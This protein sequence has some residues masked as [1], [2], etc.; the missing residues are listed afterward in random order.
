MPPGEF[1]HGER[2][3]L[4]LMASALVCMLLSIVFGAFGALYYIPD[5]ATAMAERGVSLVQLR[6]LH[7]TFASAWIF[8]GAVTCVL[9]FL[10][11]DSGEPSDGDRRR[12]RVQMTCWGVAGLGVVVTLPLG[13]TTGR[14]YLGFHPAISVLIVAGWLLFA[15]TFFRRV[16]RGFWQRPV[17]VYMWAV[18]ILYFLWTFTEGH[19][20]LLQG[21]RERPVADLQIQWKSCGTLVA[22]FNQ[23]VYGSLIYIAER[24]SGD[25]R[26]A[27][28]KAAFSLLGLGLLNSFTNYAHHTYHLPQSHVIKWVA[29]VVSMLE[30]IILVEVFREVTASLARRRGLYEGS[31]TVTER[32]FTL[33]KRWNLCLLSLAILI[34]VP[35]LNA[36][37]HGTHVVMG[38]A[39]GSELA[40]DSYILLGVFAALLTDIFPKR[41]VGEDCI[42]GPVVQRAIGWLNLALAGLV[43]LLVARG[44]ATGVTRFLGQPEPEWVGS[45]P[46][47]FAGLGLAVGWN[48]VRLLLHWAPLFTRPRDH[49]AW[50]DDTRAS[51][52]SA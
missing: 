33:S 28:S 19:A 32:F 23:M 51:P 52:H 20:W 14:E 24:R 43:L 22:S 9:S 44:L 5:L 30:V 42:H 3:L 13:I 31:P 10:Y 37:I 7:T 46:L 25:S 16:A 26:P 18:G 1:R 45:F 35:P 4:V 8:L 17:Y 41:E 36:L 27:H 38:H 39:M 49:K 11:R 29:F 2:A 6:P 12:F 34:S 21:V 40:I 15:W 50:R 47:L 48:L